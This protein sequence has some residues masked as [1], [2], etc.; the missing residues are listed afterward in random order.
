MEWWDSWAVTIPLSRNIFLLF[1]GN[2]NNPQRGFQMN[3]ISVF[4]LRW[5][6][7]NTLIDINFS[8]AV[9]IS[10]ETQVPIL[11]FELEK[12]SRNSWHFRVL[13]IALLEEH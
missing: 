8:K 11:S 12:G 3:L 5:Y 2:V 4:Q 10:A 6:F 1:K 7:N 13:K 9:P